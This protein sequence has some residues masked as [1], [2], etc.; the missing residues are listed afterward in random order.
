MQKVKIILTLITI[1]TIV[2]P[3][4]GELIL[5]RNDLSGLIIPPEIANLVNG[6]LTNGSL[7][8]GEPLKPPQLVSSLYDPI[9]RTIN[10]SFNFT[11]PFK[12]D[13]TIKSMSANVECTQHGYP[14]G[15]VSLANPAHLDT[16]E[17]ALIPVKGTWTEEAVELF[18]TAHA[19]AKTINV[20]LT[21]LN[22]DISGINLNM[23]EKITV[24][25]VPLM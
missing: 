19:G 18:A 11:N 8:T 3:L 23:N 24:P 20:D 7:V 22:V 10:F 5:Y 13:L 15:Q 9:S 17:T 2:G 16:G 25:D 14:L 6:G 4:A 1:I 21:G 12:F